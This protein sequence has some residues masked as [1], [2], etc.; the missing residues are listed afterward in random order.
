IQAL[1]SAY[2]NDPDL[3]MESPEQK[4]WREQQEATRN[5]LKAIEDQNLARETEIQDFQTQQVVGEVFKVSLAPITEEKKRFG[6]EFQKTDKDTPE[7]ASWKERQA[8]RY[9]RMVRS[10]LE[11][12][13][14]LNR[15]ANQAQHLAGQK[16]PRQR[17]R[18]MDQLAPMM[19]QR[20]RKV[21]AEVAKDLASD[22]VLFSPEAADRAKAANLNGLRPQVLGGAAA[23]TG[24]QADLTGM[25]DPITNPR[26]F[27]VWVAKRTAEIA[28]AERTPGILQGS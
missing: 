18:A 26:Q 15:L 25:P 19:Q 4:Q 2:R 20:A 1:V 10:V 14:E 5:Q 8:A 21:A 6:L 23:N 28:A 9:D 27:E 22:L 17:Q 24:G 3:L 12:D 7:L 13:H 16:D 11:S